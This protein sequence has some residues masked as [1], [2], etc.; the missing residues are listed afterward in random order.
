MMEFICKFVVP[1]GCE[2][3]LIFFVGDRFADDKRIKSL[4]DNAFRIRVQYFECFFGVILSS[5]GDNVGLG[6]MSVA[7]L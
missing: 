1:P 3:G 4:V 6:F 2:S 7:K 5:V